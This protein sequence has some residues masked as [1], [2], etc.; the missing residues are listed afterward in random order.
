M[1][2]EYLG[3][4]KILDILAA[5]AFVFDHITGA[6]V[7]IS[8]LHHEVH[9]GD[10]FGCSFSNADDWDNTAVHRL[11]LEA[12]EKDLH[13]TFEVAVSVNATLEMF[14]GASDVSGG[15]PCIPFDHTEFTDNTSDATV[16]VDPTIGSGGI[17]L[18]EIIFIPGGDKKS[19]GVIGGHRAELIVKAGSSLQIDVT[20]I[21]G[22]DNQAVSTTVE[23][24]ETS[25]QA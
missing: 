8:V 25:A 3:T 12:D 10:F 4:A 15:S 24:Y 19:V 23:W 21:S 1:G 22:S 11:I 6:L 16:T 5:T 20:N 18:S 7:A 14:R 17:Q 9:E 13:L 2:Y